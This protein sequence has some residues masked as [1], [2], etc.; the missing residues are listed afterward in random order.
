VLCIQ[1]FTLLDQTGIN[2]KG[3]YRAAR[4]GRIKDFTGIDSPYEA[5]LHAECEIDI[6]AMEMGDACRRLAAFL[7]KK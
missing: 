1:A 3:L 4:E 7:F 6:Q 5:P 2:P